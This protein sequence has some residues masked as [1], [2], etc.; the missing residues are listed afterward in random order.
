MTSLRSETI[1]VVV[2]LALAAAG[3]LLPPQ[4]SL[5]NLTA[6]AFYVPSTYSEPIPSFS[7]SPAPLSFAAGEQQKLLSIS[8]TDDAVYRTGYYSFGDGSWHAFNFTQTGTNGWLIS[9]IA[10]KTLSVPTG[11]S[12]DNYVIAYTCTKQASVWDCH[13]SK[14]QIR[15]F[16][17]TITQ[18]LPTQ[19]LI[20]YWSFDAAGDTVTDMAGSNHGALGGGVSSQKPTWT[21]QGKVGGAYLFD[22]IDD[23]IKVPDSSS[24]SI[25][26]DFTLSAWVLAQTGPTSMYGTVLC[27]EANPTHASPYCNY[28]LDIE[29]Y[30][31]SN[32]WRGFVQ[33][34][35]QNLASA[36]F[37]SWQHVAVT[38]SDATNTV[39]LY[40][41]GVEAARASIFT[42]SPLNS[43][44]E[45]LIGRTFDVRDSFKGYI[46]EVRIYNRALSASEVSQLAGQGGDGGDQC[47]T[48]GSCPPLSCQSV[49]CQGTPKACVYTPITGCG[50]SCEKNQ[51]E[52]VLYDGELYYSSDGS[53]NPYHYFDPL[54]LP[55]D[56]KNPLDYE[57]G[58]IYQHYE[59]LSQ[60]TNEDLRLIMAIWQDFYYP[61]WRE[62]ASHS[63]PVYTGV[64]SEGTIES[65]PSSTSTWGT[66]S[67]GTQ[68]GNRIDFSRMD[69]LYHMGVVLF[70]ATPHEIL[71][72]GSSTWPNKS[73]FLPLRVDATIIAVPA[74][75]TFS[76][77]DCWLDEEGPMTPTCNDGILNQG[78]TGVDCG[79]P[80]PACGST[81]GGT[82]GTGEILIVND[83]FYWTESE[84]GFYWWHDTK[85]GQNRNRLPVNAPN[86]WLSPEDYANGQTYV[87]LELV[88][89]PS[90]SS[91]V[92]IG[93]GMW[94]DDFSG[95]GSGDCGD[96][97][98]D[99]E[100]YKVFTNFQGNGDFVESASKLANWDQNPT[101]NYGDFDWE[102]FLTVNRI[103]MFLLPHEQSNWDSNLCFAAPISW[104][105]SD[106]SC[107]ANPDYDVNDYL[108]LTVRTTMVAVAA[109]KT[110]S[111]WNYWLSDGCLG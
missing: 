33:G 86:N 75:G 59:I 41:N 32:Q 98:H 90:Q 31:S 97:N 10:S 77:W 60:P 69:D 42:A 13:N 104:M 87:R 44:S 58:M 94:Q 17:T 1:A 81:G 72:D 108:P 24:L 107:Y 57:N 54:N 67:G 52:I 68:E 6:N 79:G 37:G 66:Y 95:D 5:N 64:G 3:L 96:C 30:G 19:G 106:M 26:G 22:G 103:G 11:Q 82:C 50:D 39:V 2:L 7:I 34:N 27:K 73:R 105:G 100:V 47:T 101:Y 92:D 38:F 23:M 88:N 74:G 62:I 14:W 28:A 9:Q 71:Q 55:S 102:N 16:T 43:A 53:Y 70:S 35:I 110:F 51:E 89:I 80:C 56:M 45:L 111:G 76:G 91:V 15:Q 18:S 49:K 8:I 48:D 83:D 29:Y 99:Q 4:E 63:D 21:A 36:T 46:D 65:S 84:N 78:E 12:E 25:T 20:S 40:K 61:N 85:T 93:I 109:G